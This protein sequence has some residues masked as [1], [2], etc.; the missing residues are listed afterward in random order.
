MDWPN[1]EPSRLKDLREVEDHINYVRKLEVARLKGIYENNTNIIK[2]QLNS[3][4]IISEVVEYT[5]RYSSVVRECDIL[6][7]RKE[8]Q[9]TDKIFDLQFHSWL[10]QNERKTSYLDL[11]KLGQDSLNPKK[12]IFI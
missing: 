5:S 10:M 3:C 8:L 11:V 2:N 6:F 1:N 9:G 12:N 4:L 7:Y